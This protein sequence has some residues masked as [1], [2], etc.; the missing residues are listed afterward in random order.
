MKKQKKM[1]KLLQT[2]Y[3]TMLEDPGYLEIVSKLDTEKGLEDPINEAIM[4]NAYG[5]LDVACLRAIKKEDERMKSK[6]HGAKPTNTEVL[7]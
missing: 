1:E 2:F 5:Y 7:E 4:L 6:N 3:D